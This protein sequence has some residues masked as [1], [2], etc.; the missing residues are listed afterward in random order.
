MTPYSMSKTTSWLSQPLNSLG[1]AF[2]LQEVLHSSI[3]Y[4]AAY[5]FLHHKLLDYCGLLCLP[6]FGSLLLSHPA[7]IEW[8]TGALKTF[9]VSFVFSFCFWLQL[10]NNTLSFPLSWHVC[11][12]TAVAATWQCFSALLC[13]SHNDPCTYRSA[14][15]AVSFG[16]SALLHTH[17][18]KK[19]NTLVST[20]VCIYSSLQFM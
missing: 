10:N 6:L 7:I 1:E 13:P 19:R 5:Y 9:K 12:T 8:Q 14:P 17:F 15:P 3:K 4:S 11:T 16:S 18:P 2:P 20:H